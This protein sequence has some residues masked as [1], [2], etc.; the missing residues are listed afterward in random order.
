[1]K[2]QFT[3]TAILSVTSRISCAGMD[4]M[5]ELLSFMTGDSEIY[6]HQFK[7]ICVEIEPFL[8]EQL[9]FL[10]GATKEVRDF[11]DSRYDDSERYY[12]DFAAFIASL[13]MK[14]HAHHIV[15]AIHQEDYHKIN[16][17]D[18]VKGMLPPDVEIISFDPDQE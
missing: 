4:E 13:K 7:R 9:P 5:R 16:P 12:S 17:M 1:M 10:K 2:K 11:A 14:Y 18:E 6:T 15:H 8:F 3:L